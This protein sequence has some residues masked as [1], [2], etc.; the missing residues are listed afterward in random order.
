MTYTDTLSLVFKLVLSRRVLNNERQFVNG[1]QKKIVALCSCRRV[2][3]YTPAERDARV[4]SSTTRVH[5]YTL[6]HTQKDSLD[7]LTSIRRPH[8]YITY[9][10]H[11]HIHHAVNSFLKK[12]TT[13][14][15]RASSVL[16]TNE[17]RTH[18]YSQFSLG[19]LMARIAMMTI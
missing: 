7:P 13:L 16:M 17:K 1:N 10:I 3:K 15:L 4:G 9:I 14:A 18:Q 2:S 19:E 5:G 8:A 6:S 11:S 12:S